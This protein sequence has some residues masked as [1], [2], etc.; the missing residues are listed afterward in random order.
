MSPTPGASVAKIGDYFE[1]ALEE[2][3]ITISCL[4]ECEVYAEPI[5]FRRAVSNLVSNAARETARGGTVFITMVTGELVSKIAV[6]DNGRGIAREH[7]S[8][9]FDRFYRV[10]PSRNSKGNGLGL[11]LVRSIMQIH[12]GEASIASEIGRGTTVTLTFPRK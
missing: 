9:V 8:R 5:L 6:T 7:L 11:A 3:G 4:G 2:Q 10:D 12:K 1:T